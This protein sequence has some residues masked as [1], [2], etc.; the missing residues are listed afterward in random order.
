M[1]HILIKIIE[2]EI[3]ANKSPSLCKKNC[4]IKI[5]CMKKTFVFFVIKKIINL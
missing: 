5:G 3:F 4:K 1:V 2:V